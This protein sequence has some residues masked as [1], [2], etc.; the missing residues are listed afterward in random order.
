MKN[1]LL[2]CA[3]LVAMI[4]PVYAQQR[5]IKAIE[6]EI[7][8][9]ITFGASKLRG[10]G[11]DKTEV[12]QTG[13]VEIRYNLNRIPVDIGLHLR[14]TV[15]GREMQK[16]GEHLNFS[17]G[18]F[19]ITSDYNYRRNSNCMLFAGLGVGFASFG[20]SAQ[21]EYLDDGSY[22]DN[23]SNGSIC[24]MPRIGVELWHHLRLTCAYIFEERA[25]GHFNLSIGIAIGGG[26]K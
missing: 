26:R 23:G 25:N 12:G 18:N 24:V 11:F 20:N 4:H 16:I 7:G 5:D 19:M 21:I 9:G 2:F 13:F 14:G 1:L 3:I 10:V 15:F 6:V 22:M 17:S 8:G